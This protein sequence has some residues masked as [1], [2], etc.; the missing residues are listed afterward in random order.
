MSKKTKNLRSLQVTA[1][2]TA[3]SGATLIMSASTPVQ[4]A[5]ES[6]WE[7]Q[8]E[9]QNGVEPRERYLRGCAFNQYGLGGLRPADGG[10]ND[11]SG[12]DTPETGGG[13]GPNPDPGPPDPGPYDNQ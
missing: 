9:Q 10:E 2:L 3:V 12:V 7:P 4:A 11:P 5:E 1:L 13:G 8:W 6:C